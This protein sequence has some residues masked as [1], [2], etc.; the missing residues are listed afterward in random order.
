MNKKIELKKEDVASIEAISK[1]IRAGS[2]EVF[3]YQEYEQ[4]LELAGISEF[5]IRE[6]MLQ[7]GY[8]DYETYV[9]ARKSA[10]TYEQ[11]RILTAVIAASLAAFAL[12]IVYLI[13][14]NYINEKE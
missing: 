7:N 11:K 5:E 12:F 9:Q 4:L 14:T 10:T 13:A 2:A 1:K 3:E 8:R 6:K